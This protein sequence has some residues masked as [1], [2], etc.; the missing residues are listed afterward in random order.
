MCF[1]GLLVD[2]QTAGSLIQARRNERLQWKGARRKEGPGCCS[3]VSLSLTRWMVVVV[4]MQQAGGEDGGL[5]R[6]V[7]LSSSAWGPRSTGGIV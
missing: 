1:A 5:M 2:S 4:E 3:D 6:T 7:S